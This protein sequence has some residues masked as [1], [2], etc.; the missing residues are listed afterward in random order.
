MNDIRSSLYIVGNLLVFFS[1]YMTIPG[2]FDF[3]EGGNDWVVFAT[4][5]S[6]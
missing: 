4:I 2:F 5:A 1:F 3:M 6:L